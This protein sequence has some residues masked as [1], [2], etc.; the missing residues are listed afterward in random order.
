MN[1]I[2]LKPDYENP[3]YEGITRSYASCC[4]CCCSCHLLLVAT[5]HH[6]AEKLACVSDRCCV[7]VQLELVGS[8]W[9]PYI[10]TLNE[11][12]LIHRLLVPLTM[13][14]IS[15]LTMLTTTTDKSVFL[16]RLVNWACDVFS[17]SEFRPRRLLRIFWE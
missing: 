14:V 3:C 1:L 2:D 8:I 12:C 16:F 7:P 17:S 10:A 9:L 4:S 13:A 5:L 6:L 15:W 11:S